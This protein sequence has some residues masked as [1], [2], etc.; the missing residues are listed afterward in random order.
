MITCGFTDNTYRILT[1]VITTDVTG[2]DE[3]DGMHVEM[4]EY[5]GSD[6]FVKTI[7]LS[8]EEIYTNP[9]AIN[10]LDVLIVENGTEFSIEQQIALNEWKNNGGFLL[11]Q[12]EESLEVCFQNLLEGEKKENFLNHLHN[13]TMYFHTVTSD[14]TQIP[15]SEKPDLIKYL[16]FL[17]IYI[18][19][20]GPGLYY[21]LKRK[22]K[23]NNIWICIC[24]NA[25][26]FLVIIA[27]MGIKTNISAP[28]ICYHTL[29][30]QY[31]QILKETIDFSI[32]APYNSP[33]HMYVDN[34]YRI[35]HVQEN[36]YGSSK[37]RSKH[38]ETVTISY[39]D[40]KNKITIDN[41]PTFDANMFTLKKN[42]ILEEEDQIQLTLQVKEDGKTLMGG[43]KNPTTYE[44]KNAVLVM[45]NQVAVIGNLQSNTAVENQNY[46]LY[47]YGNNGMNLFMNEHLDF[48]T[49]Q[50][51]AYEASNLA[52][53]I[54]KSLYNAKTNQTFLIGIVEN[55]N[56]SFQKN[57]GYKT[58]GTALIRIPVTINWESNGNVWCPNLKIHSESLDGNYNA[59]TNLMSSE[60]CTVDYSVQSYV[61]VD[62][63]EFYQMDYDDERYFYPFEG[64]IAVYNWITG[65]FQEIQDWKE[66]L[67]GA[68]MQQ[69]ISST[70]ILRIRYILN[71]RNY[72]VS[73][74]CMLPCI[75]LCGKVRE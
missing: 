20:V 11:I 8:P 7:L 48:S 58:Y 24:G 75:R 60:E 23:Q 33:Y 9:D 13:M 49:F 18:L 1:G 70:G 62:K 68:D 42:Q 34:S 44:I 26:G 64:K 12:N 14:V 53:Q 55:E 41:V 71:D 27:V 47:S 59:D 3:L 32:Q 21:Y 6:T 50:H 65:E 29:Y 16:V 72:D 35:T 17:M 52:D 46:Y 43:W 5:Y 2:I 4:D 40:E 39:G 63:L 66:I 30:E 31:N 69:Y 56:A 19:I 10:Q 51:P 15:V 67:T 25:V 61:S 54:W 45:P 36:T 73:R 38:A 22:N 57:T 28:Y 74:S 37:V